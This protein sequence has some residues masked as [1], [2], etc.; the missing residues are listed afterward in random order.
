MAKPTP[1]Q[2]WNDFV[3]GCS[4]LDF[5]IATREDLENI[6][7]TALQLEHRLA[8]D[9]I[10]PSPVEVELRTDRF[11]DA[12]KYFENHTSQLA[13]KKDSV[14]GVLIKYFKKDLSQLA[15]KKN[16]VIGVLGEMMGLE[17]RYGVGKDYCTTAAASFLEALPYLLKES[18]FG[19]A[20]HGMDQVPIYSLDL[21]LKAAQS[22]LSEFQKKLK[23]DGVPD[24]HK[25]REVEKIAAE[26]VQSFTLERYTGPVDP[27]GK[28][29]HKTLEAIGLSGNFHDTLY[30]AKLNQRHQEYERRRSGRLRTGILA[31]TL[32]ALTVGEEVLSFSGYSTESLGDLAADVMYEPLPATNVA[33]GEAAK[34]DAP[35]K[36]KR[37][38]YVAP[39]E[40]PEPVVIGESVDIDNLHNCP[41]NLQREYFERLSKTKVHS[42]IQSIVDD[43]RT[44]LTSDYVIQ[45]GDSLVELMLGP[46][47]AYETAQL[48]QYY[49]TISGMVRGLVA[50]GQLHTSTLGRE[51]KIGDYIL[52]PSQPNSGG[53]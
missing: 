13:H 44:G 8:G 28:K 45:G 18:E 38:G 23:L 1:Q 11:A 49:D 4:G 21:I 33:G 51:Q 32:I 12:R 53:K 2:R 10:P 27:Q 19:G 31:A 14:I 35:K 48:Q 26:L 20:D 39:A 50:K 22:E 42:E 40:E 41:R 9:D 43:F 52:Q 3:Q 5:K 6:V 29:G 25:K 24:D 34:A 15:S 7:S 47:S 17:K 37:L 36:G 46:K 30:E 16:S